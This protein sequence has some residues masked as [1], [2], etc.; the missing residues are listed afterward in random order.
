MKFF[1]PLMIVST[2]VQSQVSKED[3]GKVLYSADTTPT[4]ITADLYEK[5]QSQENQEKGYRF[6]KA[7]ISIPQIKD[8]QE[9]INGSKSL[10][11]DIQHDVYGNDIEVDGVL[12]S[13]TV[14][15]PFE[16]D[17]EKQLFSEYLDNMQGVMEDVM[18]K[19][20]AVKSG[21]CNRL[22]L[23][24]TY[25]SVEYWLQGCVKI[26]RVAQ[27]RDIGQGVAWYSIR[28][29]MEIQPSCIIP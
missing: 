25:T 16:F 28:E 19:Y 11:A 13:A 12:D 18:N 5:G 2:M 29:E 9:I 1:I 23:G 14:T 26:T 7:E 20:P 15:I 21:G 10:F 27:C 8:G 3:I 24:S 17:P 6:I 22:P 4:E